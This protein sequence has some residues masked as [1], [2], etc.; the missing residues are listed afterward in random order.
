MVAPCSETRGRPTHPG[1]AGSLDCHRRSVTY[2]NNSFLWCV[3][4]QLTPPCWC[5]CS[6]AVRAIVTRP[7]NAVTCSIASNAYSVCASFPRQLAARYYSARNV[8]IC[9]SNTPWCAP[10]E[11]YLHFAGLV[12]LDLGRD[13]SSLSWGGC[14]PENIVSVVIC[15]EPSS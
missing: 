6:L 9:R 12:V 13:V 15:S 10:T 1:P 11:V 8:S 7:M 5:L 14:K 4:A 3:L 2:I